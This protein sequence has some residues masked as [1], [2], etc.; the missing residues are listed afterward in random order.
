MRRYNAGDQYADAVTVSNEPPG[1]SSAWNWPAEWAVERAFWREVAARTIAGVLT[2]LIVGVPALIW[3]ALS[4]VLTWDMVAPAL[5][6][7]GLFLVVLIVYV[8][9]LLVIR[10]VARS[11][12]RKTLR[13]EGGS[14]YKDVSTRDLDTI[15]VSFAGGEPIPVPY[16]VNEKA[17]ESLRQIDRFQHAFSIVAAVVAL[18]GAVVG[19]FFAL[20]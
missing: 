15:L 9:L 13:A 11:K 1:K 8:T 20:L 7:F 2:I 3:A 6:G 5:I 4:G 10:A 18:A 12:G 19:V 16:F 14:E 17:K